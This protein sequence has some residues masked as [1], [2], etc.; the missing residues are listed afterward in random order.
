MRGFFSPGIFRQARYRHR[1]QRQPNAKASRQDETFVI[2]LSS[3]RRNVAVYA[4]CWIV[5][6][7]AKNCC[8]KN[9]F[10]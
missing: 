7:T 5:A 4:A 6:V 2:K 9:Q 3:L 1:E 10:T 8:R